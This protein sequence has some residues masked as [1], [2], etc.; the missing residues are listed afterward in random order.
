MHLPKKVKDDLKEKYRKTLEFCLITA[1]LLVF[2]I[3]HAWPEFQTGYSLDDI[4]LTNFDVKDVPR[5]WQHRLPPPPP[6][7][8]VPVPTEKETLPKDADLLPIELDLVEVP[9]PPPPPDLGM[10]DEYC[11][12]PHEIPPEPE[13]GF[14]AIQKRI[15]YPRL[16]LRRQ[17]EGT[18]VL[19]VLIDI[20]GNAEK[21]TVIKKAKSNM[22]FEKAA[23]RAVRGLK[24]K[25]AQQREKPVKVWVALP[26]KFNVS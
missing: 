7:P 18:V 9:P 2:G 13:A 19:G 5:T 3:L 15:K 25:P 6:I 23:I 14:H 11:F 22:G 4:K 12:I 26:I 20:D 16:A 24:W 1:L 8:N 21:I 17:I 10:Y